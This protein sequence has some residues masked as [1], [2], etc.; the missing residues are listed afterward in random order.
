LQI[1][2]DLESA[3]LSNVGNWKKIKRQDNKD[4]YKCSECDI[5]MEVEKRGPQ[6][7]IKILN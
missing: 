4:I 1:F 3:F 2:E 6:V 7:K 5:R